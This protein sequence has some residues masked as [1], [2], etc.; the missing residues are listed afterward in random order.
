MFLGL[1]LCALDG[2]HTSPRPGLRA[3]FGDA[4]S[5]RLRVAQLRNQCLS[6]S[7]SCCQVVSFSFPSDRSISLALSLSLS[8]S[9]SLALP[10]GSSELSASWW[11]KWNDQQR[12]RHELHPRRVERDMR[13]LNTPYM[14][15]MVRAKGLP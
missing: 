14:Y 3:K 11:Y 2:V 12:L 7:N 15:V 13:V 9:L 4:L 8:L 5:G 10:S 1:A 6:A